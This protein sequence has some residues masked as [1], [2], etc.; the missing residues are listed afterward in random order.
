MR[1]L[2]TGA[3]GTVGKAL[4]RAISQRGDTAIRWDLQEAPPD[5][6]AAMERFVDTVRPDAIYHLAIASQHRGGEQ[7]PWLINRHWPGELAWLTRC[8]QIPFI[9]TSTAMV[10]TD[11]ARGPFHP[12]SLPDATEG[13]GGDKAW[14]ERRVAEQN[15]DARQVR[16]GWQIGDQPEGNN[17]VAWLEEQA[18]HGTV[19]A[20]RRWKPACSFL[21]DT[22]EALLQLLEYG[23]GLY[24]LDGNR[25]GL[26]FHEIACG[27]NRIHGNRW[28]VMEDD[29]FVY[30]QRLMDDRLP[31]PSVKARLEASLF[32]RDSEK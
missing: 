25:D 12:D 11:A 1:V 18:N 17:M 28:K 7:E 16:L 15:P 30:D 32:D 14:A 27:L 23:A 5:H 31:V 19:R 3:G 22:A 29:S 26:S 4:V 6:Y 10:F 2:I 21:P 8:R 13:Y 20:S 9:F 24:H